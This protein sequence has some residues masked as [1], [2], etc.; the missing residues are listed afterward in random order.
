MVLKFGTEYLYCIQPIIKQVKH[1]AP[2]ANRSPFLGSATPSYGRAQSLAGVEFIAVFM[3]CFM[4]VFHLTFLFAQKAEN[5]R[6]FSEVHPS[7]V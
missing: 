7:G 2:T 3:L 4:C 1:E 6:G 5:A